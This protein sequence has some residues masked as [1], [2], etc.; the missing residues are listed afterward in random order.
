[1]PERQA[2]TPTIQRAQRV[3]KRKPGAD[4]E[5]V[6]SA[7]ETERRVEQDPPPAN[8]SEHESEG[9][10]SES[11]EGLI[12]LAGVGLVGT[13]VAGMSGRLG[14]GAKAQPKI[15]SKVESKIDRQVLPKV[16]PQVE[17]KI[18]S[19]V[20]SKIDRQ[21]L[22]KVDPQVESKIDS[23]VES[24]IDPQVLPKVD[25][26][27]DSKVD[28]KI[29]P[30]IQI[31]TTPP[32]R[33]ALELKRDTGADTTDG[34][35]SDSTI[36]VS[37]LE[38]GATW[39]YSLD[40]GKTWHVGHGSEISDIKSDGNHEAQV[41]QTDTAGNSSEAAVLR[42][43]LD[44]GAPTLSLRND[45]GRT[46]W[47]DKTEA[48]VIESGLDRDGITR[49]GTLDV[50]GLK[51]GAIWQFSLDEGRS[52]RA[53]EGNEIP[54][55]EMGAD[56]QK[57]VW[58]KQQDGDK[59]SG[60]SSLSFVLDT[61][62]KPVVPRLKSS[63]G[64]NEHGEPFSTDPVIVFDGFEQG[65]SM[66]WFMYGGRAG[67]RG[68]SSHSMTGESLELPLKTDWRPYPNMF[69]RNATQTDAAGN[70][71]EPSAGLDF[72]FRSPEIPALPLRLPPPDAI[73]P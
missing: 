30:P 42:F 55:R 10:G 37:G 66:N 35:T 19:N 49:D 38:E 56:G 20:E 33:P 36:T 24:K 4:G 69:I 52:W 59:D 27:A 32:A 5:E 22:P 7:A 71:S 13:A 11:V 18:D 15:D 60:L 23:K 68:A 26:R 45:T 16:D 63:E 72:E 43:R 12:G 51:E 67:E 17:S 1:M 53:G 61:E 29:E 48:S 14:G 9:R 39:R 44:T 8:T 62:V 6:A 41:V 57:T 46:Y 65:S 2:V 50:S 25:P 70:V 40:G 64:M 73:F 58:V 28:S 21:V 31:D 3:R 34:I 54:A 47:D